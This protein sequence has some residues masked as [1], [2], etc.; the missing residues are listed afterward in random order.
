MPKTDGYAIPALDT[1]NYDLWSIKIAS[2][3]R[4]K[5][6]FAA[7][8]TPDAATSLQKEKALSLITLNVT[9]H[10]LLTVCSGVDS[11]DA[12][13]IKL[14]EHFASS[15]LAQQINLRQQYSA[16]RKLGSETILQYFARTKTLVSKLSAAGVVLSDNDVAVQF[17][18]GLPSEYDVVSTVM[19]TNAKQ[20]KLDDLYH[21]LLP[22]EQKFT[23][24]QEVQAMV[25]SQKPVRTVAVSQAHGAA[26]DGASKT[27][28]VCFYCQ[29]PGHIKLHC[30][31]RKADM[32]RRSASASPAVTSDPAAQHVALTI[33]AAAAAVA[34]PDG[35]QAWIMDS[36]ATDHM[37]NCLASFDVAIP[38]QPAV[39]VTVGDGTK[40]FATAIGTV[41]LPGSSVQLK[42]V[43]CVPA[44]QYNLFSVRKA[45][46]LGAEVHFVKST[47][48]VTFN[49]MTVLTADEVA[50]GLYRFMVGPTP[51]ALATVI[52]STPELWHRRLA[53]L[54]YGNMARMV[55][56]DMVTGMDVP[57]AACKA[58]Q[59]LL[60]PPC[61]LAKQ[62]RSSFP[63]SHSISTAPLQLVHMDVCGPIEQASLGGNR[64]FATF[65]D[66]YSKL[67]VIRPLS[68]KS[69]VC[70]TIKQVLPLLEAISGQAVKVVRSDRGGEY[71][72]KDLSDYLAGRGI[73]HQLTAPYT[74][75]QNGSAERLNRTL[76]EKVRAMLH[77]ASVDKK[78]WAEALL[79]AN[80]V[81]N[82]SPVSGMHATPLELF[83]GTKPNISH[84]KIFGCTAYAHV[85]KQLRQKLDAVAVKGVMVG[86]E[87]ST[88]GYRIY[89][90]ATGKVVVSASV[91]FDE[92]AMLGTTV[93]EPAQQFVFDDDSDQEE[94]EDSVVPA[95]AQGVLP[96]GHE[97]AEDE[98][99][100]LG[101]VPAV[102]DLP[103]GNDDLAGAAGSIGNAVPRYPG[104]NRK[105]PGE[106][107][108]PP[109]SK[110]AHIVTSGIDIPEPATYA[111]ALAGE[112]S[113]QWQQAMDDEMASLLSLGTWELA[114]LPAGARALPV[115]WVYKVKRDPKGNL[116]RFKA[117]LVVKGFA[118]RPG[119]DF[120]EVFAPVSKHTTFR[121]LLSN[122][123]KHDLHLHHLDVKTAFLNGVLEEELW[124]M[125]PEGYQQDD[126]S[127][128]CKLKKTL[129]GLKQ[130]PRCWNN[131]LKDELE[132]YGFVQSVADPG[133]FVLHTKDDI[134]YLLVYVDDLLIA[135]RHL[136][137]VNMVKDKLLAS[138]D[139]RDLG[140][141]T[142]FLNIHITRNRQAGTVKITQHL[143]S[144]EL[145]D[146]FGLSSAHPRQVPLSPGTQLKTGGEPLDV[147]L[148]PYAELV[149]SL[150]YLTVCTR[151]DL[152]Q[153][154]GALA[155][156]M[157]KPTV[158]HWNAAKGVL[159]YA[160]GTLD[161][162][163]VYKQ[164][165]ADELTVYCDSDYAGDLDSR[166][167][168]TGY[169][170]ILNGGVI[171][172]NS[173]LQPTVA[174]STVEAEYM[175]ASATVKEA[176]WLRM[177][178]AELGY[179]IGT[180]SIWCDNQGCIKLS[181]NQISSNRSK[182]IDVQHHFVRERVSRKE[183]KLV[184]C[185]TASMVADCLTKPVPVPKL[186]ACKVAMGL[187]D[188]PV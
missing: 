136:S 153:A 144:K 29:K 3:L 65:L 73:Q 36:G 186:M 53:H 85:P 7:V 54:S 147:A 18:V 103:L 138:F 164:D 117:R 20:L 137:T 90:P 112:H 23:H 171:S 185:A 151:P 58:A 96:V 167:S 44:L 126:K 105:A 30:R 61:V 2:L 116:E 35:F 25:V 80:Y 143:A 49:G 114:T 108:V 76:V 28:R 104:R 166:R 152:S 125:Q 33:T 10:V 37:C 40:A 97:P 4:L 142:Q 169:V 93:T 156:Y 161:V 38:L 131:R 1:E 179:E 162:G 57:A 42:N 24:Q 50:D 102:G 56:G 182:H 81:R 119:I 75:E 173:K 160:A 165:A 123:A 46:Q 121:A 183:V 140:P 72:N 124:M 150:L 22:F 106:W 128:A 86:Y 67:A 141:A 71:V 94:C 21:T 154:V 92:A 113:E 70:D 55:T 115:K 41:Q 83:S 77:D 159:R 27:T 78:L 69:H 170:F 135:A 146:R 157:A 133:L 178:L 100:A 187:S 172:W 74:P 145:V 16:L 48:T 91:V 95:P 174:V 5:D 89:V 52:P 31:K 130:S 47:G 8:L 188:L 17:L 63:V 98:E 45:T 43:Y 101:V 155:R 148:H 32:A 82:R 149:G 176:L 158:D 118:Q 64:Y 9:D 51:A 34:V 14:K 6:C 79:C 68:H 62:P 19:Q 59:S 129:Y 84:L 122:V 107:W 60:C 11:A 87:Q 110:Q 12:L 184:Y 109:G 177:L 168:T 39:P 66:D 180:V 99:P 13:W 120:Q 175:A 88:K 134:V 127:L 111:Q 26:H 163:I 181:E 15:A 139:C 132:L